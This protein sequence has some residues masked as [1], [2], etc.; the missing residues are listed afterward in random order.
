MGVEFS[1]VG[2]TATDVTVIQG[3]FH[4]APAPTPSQPGPAQASQAPPPHVVTAP[5]PSQPT[6]PQMRQAPQPPP[7]SQPPPQPRTFTVPASP[8]LQRPA[9]PGPGPAGPRATFVPNYPEA[10]ISKVTVG[11]LMILLGPLGFCIAIFM[12][13]AYPGQV[14]VMVLF[15]VL[16]IGTFGIFFGFWYLICLCLGI[17]CLAISE[18]G[19]DRIIHFRLEHRCSTFLGD[20][21]KEAEHCLTGICWAGGRRDNST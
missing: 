14:I 15:T 21:K 13:R 2:S 3:V 17:Y 4:P 5:A 16:G 18:R 7:A 8:V 11:L 1:P 19:W 6:P 9:P 20:P 10:G 12:M